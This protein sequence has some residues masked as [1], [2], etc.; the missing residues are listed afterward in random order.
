MN[1]RDP[2]APESKGTSC[3]VGEWRIFQ[4]FFFFFF[5]TVH[6][7]LCY[8]SLYFYTQT[9]YLFF[10][11]SLVLSTLQP[12]HSLCSK[13]V[14]S[15]P[16]LVLSPVIL[17]SVAF[18]QGQHEGLRLSYSSIREQDDTV[19]YGSTGRPT[20]LGSSQGPCHQTLSTSSGSF[21]VSGAFCFPFHEVCEFPIWCFAGLFF[22]IMQHITW[23]P[24]QGALLS[25]PLWN[26]ITS[27]RR[28]KANR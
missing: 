15:L 7:I 24:Q 10:S 27:L 20:C 21:C 23:A 4:G 6:S 17:L 25:W 14:L 8:S 13:S 19:I 18:F 1:L 26:L 3:S 9:P 5:L 16:S 12:F 28:V 11:F 22:Y 2:F